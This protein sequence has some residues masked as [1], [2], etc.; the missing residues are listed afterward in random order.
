MKKQFLYKLTLASSFLFPTLAVVSCGSSEGYKYEDI[1]YKWNNINWDNLRWFDVTVHST[2]WN[3]GDTFRFETDGIEENPLFDPIEFNGRSKVRIQ[4][5]DA[6]EMGKTD[7]S[8]SYSPTTGIEYKVANA[9]RLAANELA[10]AG[11]RVRIVFNGSTSYDRVVGDVW[12]SSQNDGT[13]DKNFGAEMIKKG[14]VEPTFTNTDAILNLENPLSPIYYSGW[15]SYNN[16][17]YALERK[18]EMHNYT[19]YEVYGTRGPS[20]DGRKAVEPGSFIATHPELG[21]RFN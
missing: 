4:M 13:F 16:W 10:P 6:P 9:A 21:Y 3:D 12:Y 2:G 11:S 15:A 1:D 17:N 14:L 5:I 18:I 19:P 7:N 8:G 20:N